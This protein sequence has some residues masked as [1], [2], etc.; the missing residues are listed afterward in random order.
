MSTNVQN[1]QLELLTCRAYQQCCTHST[2]F[3]NSATDV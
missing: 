1:L 2:E 3:T